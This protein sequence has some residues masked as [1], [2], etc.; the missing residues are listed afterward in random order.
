MK[1]KLSPEFLEKYFENQSK[2]VKQV[3]RG[4]SLFRKISRKEKAPLRKNFLLYGN[5][6]FI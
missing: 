2:E 5:I 3:I 1:T 4:T 6:C